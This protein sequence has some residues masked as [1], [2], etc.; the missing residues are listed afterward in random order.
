MNSDVKLPSTWLSDSA[1]HR[2]AWIGRTGIFPALA[3]VAYRNGR[4]L[5]L[6]EPNNVSSPLLSLLRTQGDLTG[7]HVAAAVEPTSEEAE[8]VVHLAR[9]KNVASITVGTLHPSSVHKG[10]TFSALREGTI[11]VSDSGQNTLVSE[12][13]RRFWVWASHGRSYVHLKISLSSD[14]MVVP[15]L[16]QK[17][18]MAGPESKKRIHRLR[19]IYDA[20]LLGA[21]TVKMYDSQMTYRGEEELPQPRKIILSRSRDLAPTLSAFK[22]ESPLISSEGD[23]LALMTELGGKGITSVLV[24]GGYSVYRLFM[25]QH[26][27]DEVSLVWTPRKGTERGLVLPIGLPYGS[28]R[29]IGEDVWETIAWPTDPAERT[30]QSNYD[31]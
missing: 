7:A 31:H 8:I 2:S 22:G 10:K 14:G 5:K 16:G 4:L 28:L 19:G 30:A 23:M 11:P 26:V 13:D 24:E 29:T 21:T 12:L 1:E 3:A 15:A 9:Q 20:L 27:V 6:C 25:E 18:H 17:S